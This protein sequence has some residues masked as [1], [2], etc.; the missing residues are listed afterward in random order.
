[1][2]T[3]LLR[4]VLLPPGHSPCPVWMLCLKQEELWLVLPMVRRPFIALWWN[5]FWLTHDQA[6]VTVNVT[7]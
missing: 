7:A 4:A 2:K 3:M 1:M 6:K 5:I